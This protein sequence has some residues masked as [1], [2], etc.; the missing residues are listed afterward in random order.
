MPTN[1]QVGTS[2]PRPRKKRGKTMKEKNIHKS[3]VKLGCLLTL[4]LGLVLLLS[5]KQVDH[6]Q[7]NA[8]NVRT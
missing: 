7:Q 8:Q 3:S 5:V 1:A 2:T 4:R 6:L